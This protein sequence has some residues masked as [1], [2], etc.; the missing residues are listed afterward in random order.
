MTVSAH[1]CADIPGGIGFGIVRVRRV[2]VNTACLC[3][4][5]AAADGERPGEVDIDRAVG[6]VT[7]LVACIGVWAVAYR[8]IVTFA[9]IVMFGGMV[10]CGGNAGD[11]GGVAVHT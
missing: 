3:C 5:D 11:L 10:T 7:S 1:D 9:C 2:A 6:L 4:V 8:T